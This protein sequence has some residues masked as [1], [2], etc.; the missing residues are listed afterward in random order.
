MILQDEI[1]TMKQAVRP[2][3]EGGLISPEGWREFEEKISDKKEKARWPSVVTKKEVAEILKMTPRSINN[4][5]RDGRLPFIKPTGK[6]AV[7]F[8]LEF[9]QRLL[10]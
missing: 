7:R 3:Y 8:S 5:M 6:R 4:M 10:S 2:Y 1:R 9:V